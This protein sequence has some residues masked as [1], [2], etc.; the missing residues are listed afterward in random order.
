M[1]AQVEL[2]LCVLLRFFLCPNCGCV[3][4]IIFMCQSC[5][6]ICRRGYVVFPWGLVACVSL[7]S[8]LFV[9]LKGACVCDIFLLVGFVEYPSPVED[10]LT[11]LRKV[12]DWLPI[13]SCCTRCSMSMLS[14]HIVGAT[15]LEPSSMAFLNSFPDSL[16]RDLMAKV[17][18]LRNKQ[19]P[20]QFN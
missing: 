4:L 6:L 12:R 8:D 7:C 13:K 1:V 20:R 14:M 5:G 16:A 3:Y 2:W 10:W 15:L 18:V 19:S 9:T 11:T 17:D